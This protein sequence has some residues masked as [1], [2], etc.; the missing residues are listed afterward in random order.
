MFKKFLAALGRVKESQMQTFE[1]LPFVAKLWNG[2]LIYSDMPVATITPEGVTFENGSYVTAN[3]KLD[4][5]DG[6]VAIVKVNGLFTS[7]LIVKD[8]TTS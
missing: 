2:A 7:H 6:T 1:G 4:V 3:N 5:H 8:S